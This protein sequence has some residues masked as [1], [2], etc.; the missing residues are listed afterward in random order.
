M[1][2]SEVR[3]RVVL[4]ERYFPAGELPTTVASWTVMA[5][6]LGPLGVKLDDGRQTNSC[7]AP[8]PKQTHPPTGYDGTSWRLRANCRGVDPE[9]FFPER[10]EPT[11]EAKEVCKGCAVRAKCLEFAL[12]SGERQGIWGGLSE[13][14]RRK[15]RRSR[16][17]A[18]R[19]SEELSA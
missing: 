13:K 17:Q 15:A 5:R 10:G 3:E 16:A 2:N 14:E 7:A 19:A 18:R 1:P 9:L 8:S 12:T 6:I 11:N 4:A